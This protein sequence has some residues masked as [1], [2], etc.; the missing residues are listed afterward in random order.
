MEFAVH[1]WRHEYDLS[2]ITNWQHIGAV[3][4]W[5]QIGNKFV[6]PRRPTI[7]FSF[8]ALIFLGY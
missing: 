3:F 6:P 5:Q 1:I 4:M 2:N 8:V 7:Q